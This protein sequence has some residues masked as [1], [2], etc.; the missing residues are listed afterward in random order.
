ME[1]FENSEIEQQNRATDSEGRVRLTRITNS[2]KKSY[3][4]EGNTLFYKGKQVSKVD[5]NSLMLFDYEYA[6]D[7]NSVFYKGVLL[8]E[9]DSQSFKVLSEGMAIDEIRVFS[10]GKIIRSN[11]K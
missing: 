2:N 10:S 4:V 5:V 3:T 8:N 1:D 6:K 7:K 9:A 11:F